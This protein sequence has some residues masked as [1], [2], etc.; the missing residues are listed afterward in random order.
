[1]LLL[2]TLQALRSDVSFRTLNIG[3]IR[4]VYASRTI[5]AAVQVRCSTLTSDRIFPLLGRKLRLQCS[6]N[7]FKRLISCRLTPQNVPINVNL[8]SDPLSQ[9]NMH[10]SRANLF[11][12]IDKPDLSM[13]LETTTI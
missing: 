6:Q 8:A 1:M 4:A 2:P 9:R 10:I 13:I 7:A 12:H 11:M 3:S 5:D